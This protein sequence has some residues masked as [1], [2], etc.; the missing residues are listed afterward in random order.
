MTK[1]THVLIIYLV[2]WYHTIV[3]NFRSARGF[4]HMK[5]VYR[6]EKYILGQFSQPFDSIPLMIHH[7]SI[8][9]LPIKGAEHMSLLHPVIN[10]LLWWQPSTNSSFRS[11]L[12]V[13]WHRVGKPICNSH[14]KSNVQ[15]SDFL[16]CHC[17]HILF[18]SQCIFYFVSVNYWILNLKSPLKHNC[19]ISL[20]QHTF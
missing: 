20:I 16:F 3:W 17:E 18:Q 12:A 9:K 4:M 5:I 14:S 8:S 1:Y 15:Y 11:K 10:E 7:Y 13:L 19:K 6:D 2:I